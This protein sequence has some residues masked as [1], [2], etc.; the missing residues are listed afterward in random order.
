MLRDRVGQGNTALRPDGVVDGTFTVTLT[1]TG[2]RTVTGLRLASNA[3]GIWDTTSATGYWVLAVAPSLDGALLNAPGTMAVNFPVADGGSFIV[4]ASDYQDAEFLPGRTLT[5]TVTFE[6]GSTAAATTTVPTPAPATLTLAYNGMLRDRVGQGNTALGPDGAQDGT[7]TVTLSA[8]GGRTV[9]GLRLDSNAPGTWDTKGGTYF[10]ALGVAPSL[11]GALL[12]T[13][14]TMAV[15]FPV[16]DGASFVVFA[17][18]YL[19]GEFLPGRTLTLT[20]AF[21]DGSTAM[22]TTTVP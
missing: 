5:L 1:G 14:G 20:T 7:L 10:W 22:A 11:D 18:D 15:N 21:S 8:S 2:G 13:S 3:P 9:T 12:N 19:G 4:F 16:A 6:D 17:S